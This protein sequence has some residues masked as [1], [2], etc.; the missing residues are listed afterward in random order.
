M[1]I[2]QV[3]CRGGAVEGDGSR[4]G[5]SDIRTASVDGDERVLHAQVDCI[6]I[7]V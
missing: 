4:A 6:A 2:R 3:S 1:G 5:E 7:D